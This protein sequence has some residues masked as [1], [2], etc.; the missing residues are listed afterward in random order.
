MGY[1]VQARYEET[2]LGF[3]GPPRVGE[4]TYLTT[5][6]KLVPYVN[7]PIG[8]T[9]RQWDHVAE[10]H[11]VLTYPAARALMAWTAAQ[12]KHQ[13]HAEFRLVKVKCESSYEITELGHSE[14]ESF[15]YETERAI[16]FTVLPVTPEAE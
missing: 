8:V 1:Y 5:K 10:Y 11:H 12:L 6:W 7:A 15:D 4:H 3:D 2:G 14:P 16:E 9:N 13:T